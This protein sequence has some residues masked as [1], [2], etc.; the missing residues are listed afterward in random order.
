MVLHGVR[1][2]ITVV[3]LLYNADESLE[4]PAAAGALDDGQ[5]A[6]VLTYVRREW[7]E[8]APPVEPAV[9][10]AV[11][12]ATKDRTQPWTEKELLRIK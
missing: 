6:A 11:R 5:I 2:P 9:V 12:A 7:G 10:T 8:A 3:G 4:M 1:G